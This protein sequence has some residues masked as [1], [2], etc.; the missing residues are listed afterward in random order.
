MAEIVRGVN[1]ARQRE[2]A[3]DC[4]EDR[5]C[6]GTSASGWSE[7]QGEAGEDEPKSG[8]AGEDGKTGDVVAPGLNGLMGGLEFTPDEVEEAGESGGDSEE[9]GWV[10]HNRAS[11]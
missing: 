9:P 5:E 8:D 2:E 6:C 3:E 11:T 7:E 4:V 1:K 10:F